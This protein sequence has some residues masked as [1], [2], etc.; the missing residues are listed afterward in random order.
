MATAVTSTRTFIVSLNERQ[1]IVSSVVDENVLLML[2]TKSTLP[3][4]SFLTKRVSLGFDENTCSSCVDFKVRYW[5][6]DEKNE[7]RMKKS[8]GGEMKESFCCY[9]LFDRIEFIGWRSITD[10]ISLWFIQLRLSSL[11]IIECVI[12]LR[13]GQQENPQSTLSETRGSHSI[14]SPQER[15][16]RELW[17]YT[18]TLIRNNR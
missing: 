4:F 10:R 7:K 14:L 9:E 11:F 18:S 6:K 3:T 5:T 13:G 15:N 1:V 16:L 17:I 8:K 2:L 12:Q